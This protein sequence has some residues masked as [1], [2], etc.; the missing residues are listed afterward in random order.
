MTAAT[1]IVAAAGQHAQRLQ[2]QLSSGSAG[3]MIAMPLAL[4]TPTLMGRRSR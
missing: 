4:A 2:V 3:D 1:S